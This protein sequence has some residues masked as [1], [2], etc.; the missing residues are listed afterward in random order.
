MTDHPPNI[1]I[2]P[3]AD[4]RELDTCVSIQ[5]QVWGYDERDIIP[6]RLFV[7]ARR[8]GGQVFGAF[9]QNATEEDTMVGFAMALPGLR[10]G[11]PYLHSHMLAVLP[12][13][14]NAAIGRRLKFAQRDDALARGIPLMEWTFDPLEI[15]N[16]FLNI[17]RLGAI[18]RSITPD[19]YGPLQSKFQAGLQSDRLHAEWWL[20]SPHAT[21]T[22]ANQPPTVEITDTIT[23]PAEVLH[24]KTT[25]EGQK[26]AAAL[27]TEVREKFKK[28]FASGLAVVGFKRD[29]QGNGIY[30]LG[31]LSALQ[32]PENLHT[33][34]QD[35]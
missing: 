19:F 22:L 9:A 2:R 31:A 1:V 27:Q 17:A 14:R 11:T 30:Q 28:A 34:R 25:P 24:W 4:F 33:G 16:A 20:A 6:R 29:A 3:C 10:N 13:W 21:S 15:K 35:L 32:I 7:V 5:E 18:V 23:L 12:E 26:K 8:I